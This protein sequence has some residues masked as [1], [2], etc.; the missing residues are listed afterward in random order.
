MRHE[1]DAGHMVHP[2][3]IDIGGN[4]DSIV[5]STAPTKPTLGTS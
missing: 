3:L 5:G 2:T 1:L 4:V